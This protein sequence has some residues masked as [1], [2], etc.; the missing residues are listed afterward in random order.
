M[1]SEFGFKTRAD[2]GDDAAR[3]PSEEAARQ[4]DQAG[5]RTEVFRRVTDRVVA[6]LTDYQRS[7]ELSGHFVAAY[8]TE[9]A[10]AIT[11]G[12]GALDDAIVTVRVLLHGDLTAPAIGVHL[13]PE[14]MPIAEN[15]DR[16]REVLARETGLAVRGA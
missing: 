16:L 11:A 8:D 10:W 3:D 2:L 9:Q 7:C 1:A 5:E 14:G 4:V 12:D 13:A 15:A 6:V